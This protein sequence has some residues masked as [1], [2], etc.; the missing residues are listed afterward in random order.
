VYLNLWVS[1]QLWNLFF[2]AG[3]DV[4]EN[5]AQLLIKV[6]D[7]YSKDS[8]YKGSYTWAWLS[9]FIREETYHLTFLLV[10]RFTFQGLGAFLVVN[11][12]LIYGESDWT[13]QVQHWIDFV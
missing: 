11:I 6:I 13:R 3:L 10:D 7:F 12:V 4:S 9:F 5:A 8:V 1:C 2:D